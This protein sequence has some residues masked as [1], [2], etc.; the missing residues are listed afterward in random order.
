M[1]Y[2]RIAVLI[3][4]LGGLA[5]CGDGGFEGPVAPSVPDAALDR[6][7]ATEDE[8]R[9][10]DPHF[11]FMP[12]VVQQLFPYRGVFEPRAG[13]DLTAYITVD[14]EM[15]PGY[16]RPTQNLNREFYELRWQS[17][18]DAAE[19]EVRVFLAHRFL[20]ALDLKAAVTRDEIRAVRASGDG[21]FRPGSLVQI[22][23]R[24]EVGAGEGSFTGEPRLRDGRTT[25]DPRL[26]FTPPVRRDRGELRD[27]D[28]TAQDGLVVE[29]WEYENFVLSRLVKRFEGTSPTVADRVRL[30]RGQEFYQAT[31]ST[32]GVKPWFEYRAMVSLRGVEMGYVEID[33][34]PLD[35][36]GPNWPYE[37]EFYHRSRRL[38][39]YPVLVGKEA[40]IR[41]RVEQG[42]DGPQLEMSTT[43]VPMLKLAFE[44]DA[45]DISNTG[46]VAGAVEPGVR[47][48][49]WSD[50]I[51]SFIGGPPGGDPET[52]ANAVNDRGQ[53]AVAAQNAFLWTD[54]R[55]TDLAPMQGVSAM[56]NHAQVVG[57]LLVGTDYHA[58]LWD[59]SR[60]VDLGTLPGDSRSF[61]RDIN[62]QGEV[63]G[64]SREGGG[65]FLWR[66]GQ[67]MAL[68]APAG[69]QDAAV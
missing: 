8:E 35:L 52:S 61:A 39:G 19:A 64:G 33:V 7:D 36:R 49:I 32:R 14:G 51:T 15:Q 48:W 53:L 31:W 28:P 55:W 37:M 50:G 38:G 1:N 2:Q 58:A 29:V 9:G 16:L 44:S 59:G 34:V 56:N 30:N 65:P 40:Y 12:P 62:D 60:V 25:V 45:L 21:V 11:Y 41:F 43:G 47:G 22:R 4:V 17:P 26:L 5:G 10:G 46:Y 66:G 20:G 13:P 42:P 6:I 54:G 67:M 68:G 57:S 18:A 69:Y 27:F 23:M 24:V 3:T 63:V